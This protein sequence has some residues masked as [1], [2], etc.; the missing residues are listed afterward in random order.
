MELDYELNER[1]R[2]FTK[3]TKKITQ[4]HKSTIA[5]IWRENMLGYLSADII[6]YEK[7]KVFRERSSRKTVSFKEQ[8]MFE[9]KYEHIFA[10]DGL[11]SSK[12]F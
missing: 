4:P 12:C 3:P 2:D 5:S 9:D 1:D 11:L 6:C 8:I 7:R 10:P